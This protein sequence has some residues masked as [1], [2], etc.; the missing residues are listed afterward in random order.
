MVIAPPIAEVAVAKAVAA[1]KPTTRG[2]SPKVKGRPNQRSKS[3]AIRTASPALQNPLS[4]EVKRLL[5]L[6]RLAATVPASTPTTTATPARRPAEIRMPAAIP[7][8]GQNTA[9]LEG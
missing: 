7:D 9:T 3:Q 1:K 6:M 4:T 2:R 5:S 8:A